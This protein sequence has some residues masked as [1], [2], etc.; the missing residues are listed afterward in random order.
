L[1]LDRSK[2]MLQLLTTISTLVLRWNLFLPALEIKPPKK[3]T[4]RPVRLNPPKKNPPPGGGGDSHDRHVGA[5]SAGAHIGVYIASH[6]CNTLLH[7]TT[8]THTLEH[9]PLQRTLDSCTEAHIETWGSGVETHKKIVPLRKR[10]K[11]KILW[12]SD[13]GV[14]Y[15]INS[16]G[17]H[18]P[19]LFE[20]TVFCD[21]V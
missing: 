12:A 1:D 13:V 10:D 4:P 16:T 11:K 8:P 21:G 3:K 7:Y 18:P 15:R 19:E 17:S 20:L 14:L 5:H 2:Y 6:H 9:I